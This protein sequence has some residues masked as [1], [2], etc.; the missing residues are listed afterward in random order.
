MTRD[1]ESDQLAV[2][3]KL[4]SLKRDLLAV[5]VMTGGQLLRVNE[6][7]LSLAPIALGGI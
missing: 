2:L 4:K 5:M 7:P 1:S 6:N 3:K